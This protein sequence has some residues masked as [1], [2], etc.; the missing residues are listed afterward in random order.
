MSYFE[1]ISTY[2]SEICLDYFLYIHLNVKQV[3][4]RILRYEFTMPFFP[5]FFFLTIVLLLLQFSLIHVLM[6]MTFR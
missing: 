3:G 2:F 5:L 4:K 1:S 6:D